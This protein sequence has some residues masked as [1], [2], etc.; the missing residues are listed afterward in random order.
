[1]KNQNYLFILLISVFFGACSPKS[2]VVLYPAPEGIE[3]SSFFQVSIN[4]QTAFVYQTRVFFELNNPNRTASFVQFDLSGKVQVEITPTVEIK[5]VRIRPSNLKIPFEIKDG[6]ILISMDKPQKL[7]VEINGDIDNNLFLFANA[8]EKNAPKPDDPNV[9][10][11]GP[12]VHYVDGGYGIITLKSN[13]TVYLAG[14]A[15]LHARL[16]AKN[17]SNIRICGR[18]ILDGSTLLGRQPDYYRSYLCEPDTTQRPFFVHF[19]HCKNIEVEGVVL[20]DSPHWMLVFS[21]C[22]DVKVDNIKEFGYV[23]N[24]DG[25]DVVGSKNVSINDVFLRNNDDCVVLKGMPDNVENVKVTNSI[26][27][28]DRANAL[29]IG[30]ETLMTSISN[31]L[32]QN[33]DILEQRNRYIGHYA[34]GIFNGDSATVT[35][36]TYENIRVENCERLI[37]LIIEKGFYNKSEKRGKIENIHFKNIYSYKTADIHIDGFD[38]THAV[39]NVTFENL[40][41]NDQPATPEL[42]LNP[43][44]YNLSFKHE[45]ML[46]IVIP[47]T[48]AKGTEYAPVDLTP[49]CNRSLADEKAGDGKGWFDLGPKEDMAELKSGKTVLSGIPF[50][51]SENREKGAIFLRSGQFLT[52]QPYAS[53]PITIRKKADY[54]FFLQATSFTNRFVE[55]DPPAVWI[56]G[57][58]KLFF[59]Q[60]PTGTS[61]W[62]YIVRYQA[63]GSEIKI[64]VKA[65]MDVEDWGVWAPGGWVA[66]LNGKKFYIQKWDNPHP[67]KEIE[68][69]KMY[70]SLRPEVP[71]LLGLTI[72]KIK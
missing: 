10:Y 17:A 21:S 9:L 44:C 60:S 46:E 27:W 49:W 19:T 25:I 1:M 61:L 6:K 36:V 64:P 57:S 43:Y 11:F 55:K 47:S 53:Y 62:Y 48:I 45:N 37:S 63:D 15:I 7:S 50:K 12:G 29:Q 59:N 56:G 13:Q 5:S 31:V 69:I 71:V 66:M 67:D 32:F 70:S 68:S 52:D 34:M 58:G 40:Y 22:T 42:F 14:G 23:D 35:D 8:P 16:H 33:I 65:G 20:N 3:S 39:R 18:G 54:L 51:V 4:K 38:E 41:L 30:H 24:T 2:E 72:G 28:S 26:V